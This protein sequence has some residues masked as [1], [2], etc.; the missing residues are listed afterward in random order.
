MDSSLK[1]QVLAATDI[2]AVV[3][4]RVQLTRKGREF[5]GLCPFHA[6]HN[7]SM[8]VSPSKQIFRCW[9]CGAGGDAITFL[10]RLDNLGFREVLQL[11]AQR[12]GIP[13]TANTAADARA[14]QLR[15]QIL[16]AVR[17]ARE[18]FIRNLQTTPGGVRAKQYALQR[19]LTDQSIERFGLGLAAD[20]HD[21][22]VGAGRRAG[23]S[24]EVLQQAGLVGTSENGRL[25]D[26]FRN[27]LIFPIH[28]ALG[29]VVAFGGRALGDD[30]A[31]YLNS[32]ETVLFSKSRILYGL[33]L[34][35][36]PIETARSAI[37]VEGYM[38]TVMLAQ[39]GFDNVVATLGTALTDTH[40]QL[41][42]R[43]ATSIYL[44]FD[45]DAAGVRAAER[46]IEVMLS[47]QADV[48]VV[49]LSDGKDPADALLAH[50]ADGFRAQLS[51]ALGALE[52]KWRQTLRSFD[53]GDAR[54]RRR[55]VE[56]FL[57]FLAGASSGGR[58]DPLQQDLLIGRVS[59][60]LGIPSEEV[61]ERL[62]QFRRNRYRPET[63]AGGDPSAPLE[64]EYETAVRGLSGGLVT[65]AETV[66]G[67]LLRAPG[68]WRHVDD[69]VGRAMGISAT[70][71]GL[72]HRLLDVREEVGEYSLGDVLVR[73]EETA[74]CELVGAA[75]SRTTGYTSLEEEFVTAAARLAHELAVE[76][77]GTLQD[78]LRA[79]G[80]D[81]AVAF[82][83]L[84]EATRGHS[85]T[86]S[87]G[88]QRQAVRV[89][90]ERSRTTGSE[91]SGSAGSESERVA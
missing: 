20:S 59:E 88:R 3:G 67:L 33:D 8:S 2:V 48:R 49:V 50:G 82:R 60:L 58:V 89:D 15:E 84:R 83:R 76:E 77:A 73:C 40:G 23:L 47:A 69:T 54:G 57:G 26:R 43:H 30:R 79:A 52:F 68:C 13:L 39:Y 90:G 36:R 53:D 21:D 56:S 65:A 72:Y 91:R 28:D 75:T 24:A 45:S 12:A 80:G 14:A 78:A 63:S 10:R 66:L 42:C 44:C 38:D 5:V 25:Y 74:L 62:N 4:E 32:P 64:S 17:W 37:V 61:F 51:D 87:V 11:L 27:R 31:K 16:A 6:D 55:A 41:L 29:R 7:P 18:H 9:S 71:N 85:G 19:G 46:G 35:R 34:A 86:L 70:W 81:D 1:D 22:L